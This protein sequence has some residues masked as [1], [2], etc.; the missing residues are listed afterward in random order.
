MTAS[1]Q[2]N[3]AFADRLSALVEQMAAL[4]AP[5]LDPKAELPPLVESCT[6]ALQ[7]Y[8]LHEYRVAVVGEVNVGKSTLLNALLFGRNVLPE[9]I[10]PCT[11]KLATIRHGTRAKVVANY[12]SSAE[13]AE[14][15]G[16]AAELRPREGRRTSE[17]KAILSWSDDLEAARSGVPF[18]A[19][20]A[21]GSEEAT[22]EDLPDLL[23]PEGAR[24][25]LVRSVDIVAPHRFGAQMVFVDTPGL[26]D[27]N[28]ARSQETLNHI[29]KAG[30]VVF[31]TNALTPLGEQDA[32][33][34]S[35]KLAPAGPDRVIVVA[36]QIDRVQ[37][38]NRE[39][40]LARIKERWKDTANRVAERHGGRRASQLLQ[41]AP[42]M[43]TSALLPLV[44][45]PGAV[46]D[47]EF[48]ELWMRK[49][50]LGGYQ[51][52]PDSAW[53]ESGL[54]QLEATLRQILADHEGR[55]ALMVPIGK[56]ENALWGYE[57]AAMLEVTAVGERLSTLGMT[58]EELRRK[59][60]AAREKL[61]RAKDARRHLETF[62]D[63]LATTALST[64]LGNKLRTL[65]DDRKAQL[66]RSA[67]KESD[68][69]RDTVHGRASTL[70]AGY[71][72]AARD[73][74]SAS[75]PDIA[76]EMAKK[77]VGKLEKDWENALSDDQRLRLE[78]RLRAARQTE[79]YIAQSMPID[80]FSWIWRTATMRERFE[81]AA[82]DWHSAE[83]KALDDWIAAQSKSIV[84]SASSE[85]AGLLQAIVDSE[86][87]ATQRRLAELQGAEGSADK[88]RKNCEIAKAALLGV[89][90]E[91]DRLRH[92][93][94]TLRNELQG[95][96]NK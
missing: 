1:W 90:A 12:L 72:E 9:A 18:D 38:G 17:E 53:R 78:R 16:H 61:G 41:E 19:L 65:L 96:R 39:A 75:W 34:V 27:P 81:K 71:N 2:P 69:G 88:E 23:A 48:V 91:V 3:Q 54:E 24:R 89:A 66:V 59:G 37:P 84:S 43:A 20:I 70:V 22:L 5:N 63:D 29:A 86:L 51:A 35:Y 10:G 74:I 33:F 64:E 36:N 47:L 82:V 25:P 93:L 15:D 14:I 60:D 95:D 94:G 8:F 45:T 57:L 83:R 50:R 7:A 28:P 92:E 56:L 42:V 46:D 52:T 79:P 67:R 13:I 49:Y 77:M 87:A 80:P 32:G 30:A 44:A 55:D 21:K 6:A 11:A 31:V 62:A 26:F 58:L 73:S 76:N 68:T 85:T 40:Q 4:A